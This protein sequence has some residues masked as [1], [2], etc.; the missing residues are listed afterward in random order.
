MDTETMEIFLERQGFSDESIDDFLEHFGVLGQRWGVRKKPVSNGGENSGGTDKSS[1]RSRLSERNLRINTAKTNMLKARSEKANIRISELDAEIAALP[2]NSYK[3]YSL[4]SERNVTVAQR[5]SDLKKAAKPPTSGLTSTQ[6]KVMVGASV[7]GV[8]IGFH[9]ASKHTDAEGVSAAI[10]RGRSQREHGDIF[11]PKP[12]F[13]AKMTQEE[14]LKNVVQGINP[15][16]RTQ[17]GSMNCRRATFAYE[18]RRRGYD[19]V[20]TTSGIGRGQNESG[21]VNA[22]IKGDRNLL[23]RESMSNFAA[24]Q[25]PGIDGVRTRAVPGDT[26]TYSAM[27]QSVR[28]ISELKDALSRH[29]DG[30]RGEAVFDMGGFAHSMQWEV[31]KGIPHIF[32]SQKGSHF[33]V[34]SEGLNKLM[35][36]WGEP[37]VTEITRLDNVDLDLKFLSRWVSNG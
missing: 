20:A 15:N 6:K 21:L 16:H 29:P 31:F 26:R 34:T 11:K 8:L 13:S 19:V 33:P 4:N 25:N 30:A 28:K 24:L 17:G 22:L 12:E 7:A 3:R 1:I 5:D 35:D 37:A 23:S 36:K 18:L 10:R 9:V 2:K 14:A 32:D 27:T